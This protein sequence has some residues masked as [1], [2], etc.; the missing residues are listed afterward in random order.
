M[1][2]Y[3]YKCNGCGKVFEVIRKF[4][5]KPLKKCIHCDGK[6]IEKLISQSSF[7][8][9]GSGWYK[10]DYAAKEKKCGKDSEKSLPKPE[11][12]GCPSNNS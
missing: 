5:D 10:T 6:K 9:K 4:S 12:S 1:P 3:E 7:V 2:I 8:L 11:C